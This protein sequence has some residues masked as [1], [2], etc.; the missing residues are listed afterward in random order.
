MPA[1]PDIDTVLDWKGRTIIDR[2]G[3]K[4]GKFEEI[5]LDDE[6]DRPEWAA[7]KTGRFGLKQSFVP[8][9]E[10]QDVEGELQVPWE[11]EHIEG[12]PKV[13]PDGE[14]SQEEEATLYEHYGLDYSKRP[15]ESGLPEGGRPSGGEQAAATGGAERAEG[16]ERAVTGGGGEQAATTGAGER[17]GGDEQ[18]AT[19]RGGEPAG[20]AEQTAASGGGEQAQAAQAQPVDESGELIT[21]QSGQRERVRLRKYVVTEHVTRTVPVQREEVRMERE[22]VSDPDGERE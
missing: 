6:T 12:A 7:V 16:G 10:V 3:E 17:T 8:L 11:K 20:G 4:V 13:D 2:D 14:L 9:S 1:L 18:A 19:G 21:T 15:S 22:P 5:Y